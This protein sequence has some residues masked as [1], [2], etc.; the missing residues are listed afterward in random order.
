MKKFDYNY[1]YPKT[2][3]MK[4]PMAFPDRKGGSTVINT[5]ADALEIIK[6]VDAITLGM[7]KI[8]Y[9]VGWQYNG[10]D[11]K[12]PDFFEVNEALKLPDKTAH[13]S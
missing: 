8:I 2:M 6:R 4:M 10:H 7:P 13:E 1:D 9:L 11:D 5:F 3:M 12:Y